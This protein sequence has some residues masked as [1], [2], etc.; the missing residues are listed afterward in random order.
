MGLAAPR[1]RQKFGI[2]PRN[3]NWSNDTS[4]FG[5][6][7]LVKMGW[8][9]GEGLGRVDHAI[10]T[11]IR[12]KVKRDT[13]GLGASLAKRRG[14]SG[15]EL[16]AGDNSYLDNF[17]KLLGRLNGKEE[18]ISTSVER[19][20]KERIITGRWGINFV[21][22]DT[23]RS[24]WDKEKKLLKETSVR[25]R[26]VRDEEP[27]CKRQKLDSNDDDDDDESSDDTE[28]STKHKKK[29]HHKHHHHH[30]RER[31]DTESKDSKSKKSKKGKHKHQHKGK[32]KTVNDRKKELLTPAMDD[33]DSGTPAVLTSKLALRAK[34][35]RQKRA[36]VMDAKALQEIF[37]VR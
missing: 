20:R 3:T 10:T 22:G 15:D 28:T 23:L 9:P 4:R 8:A 16:D 35:I 11:H 24:T 21:R 30:H 33:S 37:M 27:A 25:K 12:V 2:D 5:H 6:R 36:A 29:H 1:N 18:E 14:A 19:A 17:Q 13:L 7:H 31:T 26:R 34:W 32:K